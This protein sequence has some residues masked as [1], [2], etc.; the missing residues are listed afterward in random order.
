MLRLSLRALALPPSGKPQRQL[1]GWAGIEVDE[2]SERTGQLAA[3]KVG[4]SLQSADVGARFKG[5][6]MQAR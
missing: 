2:F 6:G 1:P 4:T 5:L 3:I